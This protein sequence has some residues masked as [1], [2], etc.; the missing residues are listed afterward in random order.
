MADNPEKRGGRDRSRIDPDQPHEVEYVHRQFPFMSREE[1]VDAIRTNGP[2]RE[3]VMAF[4]EER[5][6]TGKHGTLPKT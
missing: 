2:G 6:K 4:L 1:I 3:A 5:S